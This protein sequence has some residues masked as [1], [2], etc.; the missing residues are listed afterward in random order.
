[1]NALSADITRWLSEVENSKV[2]CK[3]PPN[4]PFLQ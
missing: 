1:L 4:A 3:C 2:H